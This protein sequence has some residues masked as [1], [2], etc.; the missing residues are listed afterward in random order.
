[1]DNN[2][3]KNRNAIRRSVLIFSVIL[4]SLIFLGGSIVFVLSYSQIIRDN[5]GHELVKGIEIERIKLEASV[6]GEIALALKMA[7]SPVVIKHFLDPTDASLRR[8]AI[9]EIEG[10]RQS[11][12]SGTVFWATDFDKEFYFSETDHYTINTEDRNNYWYR[13]TLYETEKY[14]FNINYNSEI[15]KIML[16]INAPV[17][18]SSRTPIGLV[19]TG[20]DLTEFV[21]S[22]YKNHTDKSIVYFFNEE[23]EITGARNSKLAE[24]KVKIAAELGETGNEIFVKSKKLGSD[25]YQYFESAEGVTA[26]SRVPALGWYITAI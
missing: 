19:G 3:N 7:T 6:N 5:T 22:I 14:N 11:F 25:E 15:Q 18:D 24:D 23:G 26:I 8:I 21:G 20:I 1:M 4:F 2:Q 16:W 9:D 13:M 10:Y 12:A 17:F